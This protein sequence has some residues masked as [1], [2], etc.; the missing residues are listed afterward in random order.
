MKIKNTIS[1]ILC[2][3]FLIS[4]MTPVFATDYDEI[5]TDVEVPLA[6]EG[7]FDAVQ[8]YAEEH[9]TEKSDAPDSLDVLYDSLEEKT[10]SNNT[11]PTTVFV[12]DQNENL[13]QKPSSGISYVLIALSSAF[14]GEKFRMFEKGED[15]GE[16][17]LDDGGKMFFPLGRTSSTVLLVR[18]GENGVYIDIDPEHD[19]EGFIVIE[20]FLGLQF[21]NAE[22]YFDSVFGRTVLTADENGV[23]ATSIPYDSHYDFY[24]REYFDYQNGE[25]D[26]TSALLAKEPSENT[27]STDTTIG[28]NT[29]AEKKD[30]EKGFKVLGIAIAV[31][32][33]CGGTAYVLLY[34][35]D[36]VSSLFKKKNQDEES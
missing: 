28:T 30:I 23:V 18:D 34:K 25:I 10:T 9:P 26:T 24:L 27:T 6:E 8:K 11:E 21:A 17:I 5:E 36:S 7:V 15:K 22:F 1:L 16:F 13:A 3:L 19:D 33:L 35:K 12:Q 32:L 2:F 4:F 20:I 31:M 14:A 29:D